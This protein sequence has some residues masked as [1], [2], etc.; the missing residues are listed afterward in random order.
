MNAGTLLQSGTGTLGSGAAV[1]GLIKGGMAAIPGWGWAALAAA[2]ILPAILGSS[3]QERQRRR[4]A[5]LRAAEI[6]ASPWTGQG[7]STQMQTPESNVWANLLGAGTN[8]LGQ[9]QALEKARRDAAMQEQQSMWNQMLL[10]RLSASNAPQQFQQQP[11]E[12]LPG[13]P[14]LMGRAPSRFN[15]GVYGG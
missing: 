10:D 8:V 2:N 12:V 14:L 9:G 15:L 7:P 6:E 13:Q 5:D 11:T 3:A 1:G 4:E